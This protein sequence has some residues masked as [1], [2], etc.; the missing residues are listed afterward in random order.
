V[1]RVYV[2]N[3]NCRHL[4]LTSS[5]D[6]MSCCSHHHTN[7]LTLMVHLTEQILQQRNQ[8]GYQHTSAKWPRIHAQLRHGTASQPLLPNLTHSAT[9]AIIISHISYLSCGNSDFNKIW[10]DGQNSQQHQTASLCQIDPFPFWV[11]AE[12][13][14]GQGWG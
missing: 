7:S 14:G 2:D 6:P 13:N 3:G 5:R 1:Y 8:Q 11:A 4:K 9:S 10:H 12:Q